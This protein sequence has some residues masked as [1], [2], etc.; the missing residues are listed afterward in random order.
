MMPSP[1]EVVANNK[2]QKRKKRERGREGGGGTD[3]QEDRWMGQMGQEKAE[4]DERSPRGTC[5]K[6][7]SSKAHFASPANRVR[8]REILVHK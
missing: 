8:N 6:S 2:Q 7:V 4:Q 5:S 1:K 3:Q